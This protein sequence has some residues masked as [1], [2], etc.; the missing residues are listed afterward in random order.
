MEG[1]VGV[2]GSR[3][4]T[5]ALTT[6]PTV[7]PPVDPSAVMANLTAPTPRRRSTA[8]APEGHLQGCARRVWPSAAVGSCSAAGLPEGA[9]RRWR[10]IVRWTGRVLRAPWVRSIGALTAAR[11]GGWGWRTVGG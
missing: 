9:G 7:R 10:F 2:R 5:I 8:G 6:W 1:V 4:R 11:A 3:Y